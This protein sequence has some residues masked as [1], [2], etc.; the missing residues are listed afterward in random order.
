MMIFGIARSVID[1]ARV[2]VV[3]RNQRLP[4]FNV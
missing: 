2:P 4:Q 1:V 3:Q